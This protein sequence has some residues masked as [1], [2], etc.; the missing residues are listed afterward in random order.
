M[1]HG[2]FVCLSDFRPLRRVEDETQGSGAIGGKRNGK[3]NLTVRS[4][5]TSLLVLRMHLE[6]AG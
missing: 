3:C 2:G 5:L 4:V 6:G 1:R